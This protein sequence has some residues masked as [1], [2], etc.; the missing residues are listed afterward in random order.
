MIKEV[1]MPKYKLKA[2]YTALMLAVGL[3][4]SINAYAGHSTTETQKYLVIATGHGEVF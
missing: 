3:V 2:T 4:S 1:D